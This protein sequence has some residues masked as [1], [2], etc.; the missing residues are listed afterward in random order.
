[1]IFKGHTR[2]GTTMLTL[3]P[4]VQKHRPD[5]LDIHPPPFWSTKITVRRRRL[6]LLRLLRQ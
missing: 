4:L 1:M 5:F 6:P 2:V 3:G